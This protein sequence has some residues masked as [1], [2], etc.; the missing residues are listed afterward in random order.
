MEETETGFSVVLF[1]WQGTLFQFHAAVDSPW[2][3]AWYV[4]HP[5]RPH[6]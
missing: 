5:D 6:L 3:F 2:Y 4:P 1:D